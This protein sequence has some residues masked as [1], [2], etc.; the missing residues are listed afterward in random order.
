M[1][2]Q[3]ECRPA[4]DYARARRD[5]SVNETDARFDGPDRA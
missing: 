4:F 3:L 2:F 5:T 1:T